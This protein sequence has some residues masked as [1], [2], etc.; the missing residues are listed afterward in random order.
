MTKLYFLLVLNLPLIAMV[1]RKYFYQHDSM[2]IFSDIVILITFLVL[3]VRS[4]LACCTL[5]IVYYFL[6]ATFLS[7]VLI[8]QFISSTN[9]GILG[10][11][12]RATFMPIILL[13]VSGFFINK[14]KDSIQYLF[15]SASFWVVISS[16]M[17]WVQIYLG[18]D[19][20]INSTWGHQGL[21]IGDYVD[22]NQEGIQGLFR[23]TSIYMHTGQFGQVIF[24]LVLFRWLAHA[25]SAIRL[26]K[27]L[28]LLILFDLAV[29]IA[30][31]QR[32]AMLFLVGAL[33]LMLFVY[34]RSKLKFLFNIMAI[35]LFAFSLF[36]L[37]S[38]LYPNYT[39][40]V[41][42]RFLG[43]VYDI[44]KRLNGNLIYSMQGILDHYLLFGEGF[45][46]YTFGAQRF[47]GSLVYDELKHYHLGE[48]SL[49]RLSAEVGLIGAL[50]GAVMIVTVIIRAIQVSRQRGADSR[51]VSAAFCMIWLS[52]LLFW[53]NT[54]DVFANSL[55][56]FLGSGMA[57]GVLLLG[58][59]RMAVPKISNS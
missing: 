2:L 47:G 49:I 7:W 5:P 40:A 12:L 8:Q 30:S 54:A 9:I 32:A 56:M 4:K 57:G 24:L 17:A 16:L 33:G 3:L 15:L 21:G 42:A 36:F 48:S 18:P 6:L 38:M 45:G 37:Y 13:F 31:G 22:Q 39:D 11:G 35:G 53:C 59:K 26:S 19:N 50:L 29:V 43:G 27:P 44:P 34:Q 1:I 55:P 46:R 25:S 51:G 58:K 14:Y 28:Y 41:V 23:P 10:V 52:A 20:P